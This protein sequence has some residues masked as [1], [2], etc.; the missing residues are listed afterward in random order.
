MKTPLCSIIGCGRIAFLLEQDLLRRKPCTHFG[1]ALSAGLK[2]TSACDTNP[3]RLALFRIASGI[4][5]D[6][7]FTDYRSLLN[8][9]KP[10]IAIISTWTDTHSKIAADAIESGVKLIVLEKPVSHS[11]AEAERLIRKAREH[12]ST[13]IVNHERR[14]DSRY[15]KVRS[16][17]G[18]GVIGRVISVNARM[19]TGRYGGSSS[20]LEGGGPLLHDGTHLVDILRFFFGDIDNA[21]G[22]FSRIERQNGYEDSA[23]AWLKTVSGID[24]F[25]EAGGGRKYFLFELEI[26]GTEGKII[27]GNGCNRLFKY[28]KSSMYSGFNDLCEV[29]FPPVKLNNCFTELYRNVRRIYNGKQAACD[30]T[31]TDGYRSLEV[32]HGIYHSS[33][34]GK[35]VKFP[36]SPGSINIKKIFSLGQR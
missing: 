3:E 10:D 31:L 16:M 11:L 29:K 22:S 26:W 28:K 12:G 7:C 27:I 24:I 15:R 9:S 23:T 21:T 19:H 17:I 18:Q 20:I 4:D 8:S 13:V 32:I 14:F 6:S 36:V 5:S 1:G 34:T 33:Y 30:S 25:L 2:I 35:K